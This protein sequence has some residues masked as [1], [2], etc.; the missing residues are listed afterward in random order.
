MKIKI[1]LIVSAAL[2]II[3]CNNQNKTDSETITPKSPTREQ[4]IQPIKKYEAEM[5]RSL[6]LN[7]AIASQA[8]KAYDDFVRMFPGDS[9]APDFL[10]K[11][12]EITTAAKQYPQALIYYQTITGKYPKYKLVDF[13]LYMQG[14]LLD[15][16]LNDDAKAKVIYDEVIDKYPN[17]N[18][19]NDAKAAINNLGKSDDELIKEIKKKNGQK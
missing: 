14:V 16:Y 10:F 5:H 18:Y 12:G 19:A 13:S 15:N 17:S 2:F 1:Y 11:A 6:E 3:S 4:Y 7:S 9:L 8:I